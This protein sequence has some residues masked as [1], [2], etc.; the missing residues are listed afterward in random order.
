MN[1]NFKR[2][3]RQ[4]KATYKGGKTPKTKGLER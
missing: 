4:T 1:G 3:I 2:T